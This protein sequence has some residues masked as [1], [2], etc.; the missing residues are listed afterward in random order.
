MFKLS[1]FNVLITKNNQY[2]V[3]NTFTN[4]LIELQKEQFEAIQNNRLEIFNQE[5]IETL[6][7]EGICVDAALDEIGLLRYA[8]DFAKN[9][10]KYMEFVIAPTLDCNFACP[11]C[12]ETK[13]H[14]AM[15]D[16]VRD[17]IIDFYRE[18]VSTTP[19]KKVK[20]AWYGGEP[21]LQFNRIKEMTTAINKINQDY[22]IICD[23][24]M[25]TNGYLLTQEYVEEL[26][27][28]NF[29][30]IQITIDGPKAIHDSRRKLLSGEGTFDKIINNIKLFK[31]SSVSVSIR[32]NIDKDNSF[33]YNKIEE[34][35]NSFGMDNIKI[36]PALVEFTY[37]QDSCRECKCM[38]AFEFGKFAM[39]EAKNYYLNGGL[40]FNNIT[41][42]CGA[43]HLHSFVIDDFGDVYKCWN[44]VGYESEKLFSLKNRDDINP[45]VASKYL[46][47]DPFS[48]EECKDCPY[49]PICGGGC[50][51]DYLCR[52]THTCVPE[53]YLYE[54]STLKKGGVIYESD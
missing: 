4:A 31:G 25:T 19:Y 32:V 50:L 44:S 23:V 35:I 38:T 12:F 11:Y 45:I 43:E 6:Y 36:Y 40:N 2:F 27:R 24:V 49:M 1:R 47:R 21:L 15:D 26:E 54:I 51:Y 8:Y 9:N 48:E 14:H 7:S 29:K 18:Q 53:R 17:L 3:S 28:L 37:N 39:N 16:D 22:N 34:M 46:G 52:K 30:Y 33:Y 41:V 10:N 42:N 5:E 13:R 20:L